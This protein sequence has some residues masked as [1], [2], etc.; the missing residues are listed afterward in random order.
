MLLSLHIRWSAHGY[1]TMP[2]FT[3]QVLDGATDVPHTLH[4][5]LADALVFSNAHERAT[6]PH[7]TLHVCWEP[8]TATGTASTPLA[9]EQLSPGTWHDAHSSH[10]HSPRRPCTIHID[11]LWTKLNGHEH[12][13]LIQLRLAPTAAAATPYHDGEEK[14]SYMTWWFWLGLLPVSTSWYSHAWVLSVV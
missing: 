10:W 7:S 8:W 11:A 4:G 3:N 2:Y 14:E 12:T 6:A 13:N 1:L 5:V 9:C